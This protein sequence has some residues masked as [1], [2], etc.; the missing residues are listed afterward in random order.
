MSKLFGA[1]WQTTLTGGLQAVFSALVTGALT[2][3]SNWH[4][5]RQV[6]LFF[7]VLVGTFFGITFA[8]NAKD[9]K[10]TGGLVQ[11][12]ADGAVAAHDAQ[13]QSASVSDTKL[14]EPKP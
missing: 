7:L 2:F 11:Q 14:A 1:N 8:A 9:K 4:D 13:M 5:P 12:T 6:G 3:P 10:V